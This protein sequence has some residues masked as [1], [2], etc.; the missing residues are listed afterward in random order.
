MSAS[1]EPNEGHKLNGAARVWRALRAS[2]I[3][4]KC[5]RFVRAHAAFL[6]ACCVLAA[7]YL[8]AV[9][10]PLDD[11][12][13]A[14][15]ARALARAPSGSIVVVEIDSRSLREAEQWPWPRSNF[16]QAIH[17]LRVAGAGL[18]GFDVDFSARSSPEDDD[19]LRNALGS[20]PGSVILPTFLQRGGDENTPLA[21]LSADSVLASV[22]IPIDADGRVRR[23]NSG[24]LHGARYHASMASALSGAPY[25]DTSQF[26]IDYGIRAAAID[27]LSFHDV[28]QG[29]FDPARVRGKTILIGATALELGDNFSTPASPTTPGV[30]IHALAYES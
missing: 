13:G 30:Y 2:P 14:L 27:H 22:N 9:T 25:G 20:D 19:A 16:A 18:I 4:S 7:A 24:I 17:N 28:L 11:T 29:S 12:L 26:L 3:F 10:N 5:A 15:R 8:G 23:Y 21:A 6:A 1:G